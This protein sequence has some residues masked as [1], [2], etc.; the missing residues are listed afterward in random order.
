MNRKTILPIM[1]AALVA[2]LPLPASAFEPPRTGVTF[3]FA[4]DDHVYGH[5]RRIDG[6]WVP[7]WAV[8]GEDRWNDD[9]DDDDDRWGDD[10][11]DDDDDDDDDRLDDSDDDDDDG[12][13]DD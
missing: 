4:D 7:F 10:R 8:H 2:A 5:L 12:D 1:A 3:H 11:W 6:R 9:N 13:G